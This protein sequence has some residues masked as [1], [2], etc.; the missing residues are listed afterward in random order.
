[1]MWSRSSTKTFETNETVQYNYAV[2]RGKCGTQMTAVTNTPD[3]FNLPPCGEG[4]ACV[5]GICLSTNGNYCNSLNDCTIDN[6]SCINNVCEKEGV[7]V[8]RPCTENSDCNDLICENGRCKF[9]D[10]EG[11][12]KN[13]ECYS[14]DDNNDTVCI[15]KHC[16]SLMPPGA[17]KTDFDVSL[18]CRTDYTYNKG[19][20][21]NIDYKGGDEGDICVVGVL[22]CIDKSITVNGTEHS[23][24]CYSSVNVYNQIVNNENFTLS[25]A[26]EI[27]H[28]KGVCSY[29]IAE[30]N[31]TCD[32]YYNCKE[33]NV[34]RTVGNEN[35]CVPVAD[36][37]KCINDRCS[38]SAE[39]LNEVCLS[40]EICLADAN[41]FSNNCG[42]DHYIYKYDLID[43]WNTVSDPFTTS[44]NLIRVLND[45]FLL[46]T[47][48][49]IGATEIS[50]STLINNILSNH[51][52]DIT[53]GEILDINLYESNNG[54][55]AAIVYGY[56]TTYNGQ[57][58]YSMWF[59]LASSGSVVAPITELNTLQNIK[60][61][62]FKFTDAIDGHKIRYMTQFSR[63]KYTSGYSFFAY[64]VVDDNDIMHENSVIPDDLTINKCAVLVIYRF[65]ED[66]VPS[67][68]EILIGDLSV[69]EEVFHTSVSI[70]PHSLVGF[71]FIEP[72]YDMENT[73]KIAF[74]YNSNSSAIVINTYKFLVTKT[75]DDGLYLERH[76]GI[77]YTSSDS[78][79]IG[80]CRASLDMVTLCASEIECSNLH[81]IDTKVIKANT[82][83]A[84]NS[85]NKIYYQGDKDNDSTKFYFTA[86]VTQ[87][88][89]TQLRMLY[90]K[91]DTIYLVD[92]LNFD[93][94]GNGDLYT[95]A[96]KC[97]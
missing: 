16:Y 70:D 71:T 76:D 37:F 60:G 90:S 41:C 19:Y 38:S 59:T 81:L 82:N 62:T 34:C 95:I 53:G 72:N 48:P 80:I 13:S 7:Y 23:L 27:E 36:T 17:A 61:L 55:K 24:G 43:G 44:Y 49:S 42:N 67:A 58:G 21:V 10:S 6:T 57:Q 15:N 66:N 40:K 89:D 88:G 8:N 3:S 78:L 69:Y 84:I 14:G 5:E 92:N 28:N 9:K 46:Y 18:G 20:C 63:A 74:L 29:G 87:F 31:E 12:T 39:C 51:T 77:S 91:G 73:V 96:K 52:V 2:L 83:L 65:R 64:L 97:V 79:T 35:I 68:D 50:Y 25:E 11:C 47:A 26:L 30:I 75:N 86:S 33:P 32:D 1:M 94:T 93:I 85:I 56:Q 4:L 22:D 54:P 45:T